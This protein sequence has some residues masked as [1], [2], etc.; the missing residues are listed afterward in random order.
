MS[1]KLSKKD[2]KLRKAKSAIAKTTPFTGALRI[3]K[4]LE[5]DQL[6]AGIIGLSVAE[7][8]RIIEK[9][10][11]PKDNSFSRFIAV[12]CNE[13]QETIKR[14]YPNAIAK[15]YKIPSLCICVM[16][17]LDNAK[18]LTGVSAPLVP[19]LIDDKITID[20]HTEPEKV[21]VTEE[22]KNYINTASSF[23]SLFTQVQNYGPNFANLLIKTVG[24]MLDRLKS[25]EQ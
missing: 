14:L 13:K 7:I 17:I 1:N 6:F 24:A 15:P 22:G 25:E 19:T 23:C 3:A 9:G 11:A 21:E 2:I 10:E 8:L 20:I 16:Q 4:I 12:V 5:D 18:L